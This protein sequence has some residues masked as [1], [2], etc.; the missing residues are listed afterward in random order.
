LIA[1]ARSNRIGRGNCEK[2]IRGLEER[3]VAR[4]EIEDV[5]ENK[6]KGDV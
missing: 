1:A 5:D 4:K 2:G 6:M 3:D